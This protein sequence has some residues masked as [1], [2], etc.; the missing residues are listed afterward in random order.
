MTFIW[1]TLS[2]TKRRTQEVI[3]FLFIS[4]GIILI[5]GGMYVLRE[6]RRYDQK[7]A[8]KQ[9]VV[10][11]DLRQAIPEYTILGDARSGDTEQ[12]DGLGTGEATRAFSAFPE[13]G[14]DF[15]VISVDGVDCT[16]ILQIPA[17]N[18]EVAVAARYSSPEYMAYIANGMTD[19][20]SFSIASENRDS[21]LGRIMDLSDQNDVF[22]IDARGSRFAYKVSAVYTAKEIPD[23]TGPDQQKP[24][25]NLCCPQGKQWFVAECTAGS[26]SKEGQS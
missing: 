15:A 24:V 14:T 16:G 2:L 26:E 9:A 22:F 11:S 7:M 3:C 19:N 18:L 1:G 21:L 5:I 23:G 17:L 12:D 10:L 4:A 20:G 25:L 6:R 13:S 8:E